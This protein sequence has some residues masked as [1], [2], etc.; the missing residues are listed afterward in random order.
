MTSMFG[1]NRMLVSLSF[2]VLA[3]VFVWTISAPL[4]GQAAPPGHYLFAWAGDRSGKGQDFIAVIDADPAS[5][6]YG[7]LVASAASGIRTQQVHHT[8]YWMPE[9][10]LLFVTTTWPAVRW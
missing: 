6:D 4:A 1:P 7:R 10:G 2:G 9:S 5:A 3:F 8:E